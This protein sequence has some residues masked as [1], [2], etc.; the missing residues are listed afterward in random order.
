MQMVKFY[1]KSL[2]SLHISLTLQY[3]V[4]TIIITTHRVN[5]EIT[6]ELYPDKDTIKGCDDL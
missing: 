5:P 1:S 3:A 6:F 2:K 4:I